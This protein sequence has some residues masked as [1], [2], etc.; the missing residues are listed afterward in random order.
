MGNINREELIECMFNMGKQQLVFNTMITREECAYVLHQVLYES[1]EGVFL[2]SNKADD[3]SKERIYQQMSEMA[4]ELIYTM[5]NGKY[6]NIMKN[7]IISQLQEDV[8]LNECIT[9]LFDTFEQGLYYPC[10]CGCLP[11]VERIV[12]DDDN[13]SE[14]RI[15]NLFDKIKE[16]KNPSD[17]E[18]E[19]YFANVEGFIESVYEHADFENDETYEFNRHRYLHGRLTHS[20]SKVDCLKLFSVI[21]SLIE[22]QTK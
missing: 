12:K 17:L 5:N 10:L 6:Y 19:L 20:P 11:M 18:D 1:D 15:K 3:N 4:V 21:H 7:Y 2:H 9:Q 22:L 13:K 16:S 14:F 8:I